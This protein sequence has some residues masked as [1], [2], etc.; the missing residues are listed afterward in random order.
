MIKFICAH[1]V[2]H[3]AAESSDAGKSAQCP[4][5]GGDIVVP[6]VD[7]AGGNDPLWQTSITEDDDGWHL[8]VSYPHLDRGRFT[9]IAA[10]ADSYKN[11]NKTGLARC[12]STNTSQQS[13]RFNLGTGAAP[14]RIDEMP[15]SSDKNP[16]LFRVAGWLIDCAAQLHSQGLGIWHLDRD[17]CWQ[18][19]DELFLIPSFWIPVLPEGQRS[20]LHRLPLELREGSVFQDQAVTAD[21]FVIA[22]EVHHLATGRYPDEHGA[23]LDP[24]QAPGIDEWYPFLDAGLRAR[25]GRRPQSLQALG[26]LMPK[27]MQPPP[28]TSG[29]G[30]HGGAPSSPSDPTESPPPLPGNRSVKPEPPPVQQTNQA[31]RMDARNVQKTAPE[32]AGSSEKAK[33]VIFYIGVC[34]AAVLGFMALVRILFPSGS[35]GGTSGYKRGFADTVLQYPDRTYE[36]TAWREVYSCKRLLPADAHFDFISGWSGDAFAIFGRVNHHPGGHKTL[37]LH[38]Y[39]GSWTW[40]GYERY[41]AGSYSYMAK[42]AAF[43]DEERILAILPGNRDGTPYLAKVTRSGITEMAEDADCDHLAV[44]SE[45][46]F[47]GA[48]DYKKESWLL[49]SGRMSS[50]EEKQRNRFIIMNDGTIAQGDGGDE[51]GTGEIFASG[52]ISPGRAIGLFAGFTGSGITEYRNGRWHLLSKTPDL[53]RKDRP[54]PWFGT[55]GSVTAVGKDCIVRFAGGKLTVESPSVSGQEIQADTI[56]AIWGHD[57]DRYWIVDRR[58]NVYG[59]SKGSWRLVVRGLELAEEETFVD[60]WP[61]PE[62]DLIA[63]SVEKVFRLK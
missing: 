5:C 41:A 6:C 10:M 15:G 23:Q 9:E 17:S 37:I 52:T 46:T 3:I 39:N 19:G 7:R 16:Q 60:V 2:Q 45:D 49:Q 14:E 47:F 32:S 51:L 50:P 35:T 26:E 44:I 20:I 33:R 61:T 56:S 24:M 42:D 62:G 1:C 43:L 40:K 53:K 8:T 4:T 57:L 28:L 27:M 12:T 34:A 54:R 31:T 22:Q 30:S 36:G 55:D 48:D 58:G 29:Q 13:L 63:V 11:S 59:H 25:A 21:I 38:Y 18:R